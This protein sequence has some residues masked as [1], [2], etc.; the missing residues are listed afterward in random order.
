LK[1]DLRKVVWA[2]RIL[3]MKDSDYESQLP[4]MIA[5]VRVYADPGRTVIIAIKRIRVEMIQ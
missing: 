4:G 5:W 3:A 1:R 2:E